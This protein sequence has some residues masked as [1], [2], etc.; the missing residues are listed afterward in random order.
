MNRLKGKPK[1]A[2]EPS[3][4]RHPVNS[5]LHSLQEKRGIAYV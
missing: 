5:N 2:K 1:R 3:R 4:Q